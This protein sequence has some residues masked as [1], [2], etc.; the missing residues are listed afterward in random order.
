MEGLLTK[1]EILA[2]YLNKVELGHRSFGFGAA[3]Q[4]YYGKTVKQLSL[5]EMATIAGL[6]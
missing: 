6:P 1:D 4:V 2:L 3:A 5:A